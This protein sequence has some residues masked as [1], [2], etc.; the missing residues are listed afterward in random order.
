[1]CIRDRAPYQLVSV[2][3]SPYRIDPIA[4]LFKIGNKARERRRGS[5]IDGEFLSTRGRYLNEVGT[6][7]T[8]PSIHTEVHHRSADAIR[9]AEPR[10]RRRVRTVGA[11]QLAKALPES[12]A[13][14]ATKAEGFIDR[15]L[16]KVTR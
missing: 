8:D 3:V 11:E 2:V 7:S 10:H 6:G 14:G 12:A 13:R 1:M 16:C 4:G 15:P 5:S 9:A